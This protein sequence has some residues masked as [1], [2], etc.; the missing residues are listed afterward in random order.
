MGRIGRSAPQWGAE[1]QSLA[2]SPYKSKTREAY[3]EDGHPSR[4]RAGDRPLLLRKLVPDEVDQIRAEGRDLLE[5]PP[6][7]HG[8]AEARRYGGA[9]RALREEVRAPGP[10]RLTRT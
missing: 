9:R 4:L 7:L 5:V 6:L 8:Q 10:P 3:L 2:P 1:L